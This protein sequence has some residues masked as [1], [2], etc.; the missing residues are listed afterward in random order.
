MPRAVFKTPDLPAEFFELD[1]PTQCLIVRIGLDAFKS[2][3]AGVREQVVAELSDDDAAKAAAIRAEGIKTAMESVRGRLA[4]ADV[5]EME[6]HKARATIEQLRAGA[7]AIA[8]KR[9]EELTEQARMGFEIE[10][11]HEIAGLKEQLAT[12]TAQAEIVAFLKSSHD[13]LLAKVA[14]LEVANAELSAQKTKSSNA[15][16][17]AGEATVLEMLTTL[18]VPTFPFAS[19]KDTTMMSHAADFHLWV[20]RETGKKVKILIDSKK[21]KKKIGVAE[22]EKLYS[23]VDADDEAHGGLMVSLESHICSMSQFQIAR[24]PK[25]KPVMFISFFEVTED[26]RG[27]MLTWAVRSLVEVCGAYDSDGRDH[28]IEEIEEFLTEID[29]SVKELDIVIRSMTKSM[30]GLKEARGGILRKLLTFRSG[31]D[32]LGGA[33]IDDATITMVESCGHIL[34]TGHRCGRPLNPGWSLCKMHS[35]KM[36]ATVAAAEGAGEEA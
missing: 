20:M 30:E 32:V 14:T 7:D 8:A 33:G 11:L 6:L 9:A 29:G 5:L 35:R 16:G 21:Y 4:D 31:K 2:L 23:D 1:H 34:R 25:Q 26:L 24:S 10:K 36:A 18:I 19:V 17:K 15:I 22:I 3:Q 28:M 12:A 27:A 13:G